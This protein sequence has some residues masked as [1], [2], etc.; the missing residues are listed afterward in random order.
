MKA[1]ALLALLAALPGHA[2]ETVTPAQARSNVVAALPPDIA[3]GAGQGDLRAYLER[4]GPEQKAAALRS[5]T[6]KEGELGDD[7]ATLNVIGQAYAGLGKV[8]EARQAAQ[9][10]L[11]QNPNDPEAKRLMGWVISQEKLQGREGGGAPGGDRPGGGFAPAAGGRQGAL[12]ALEQRIERAFRRGQRSAEFQDTMQD[13]RG[14]SVGELKAAGIAFQRAAPDQKDAVMITRQGEGFTISIRDDAL[15]SGGDTEA[16]AAAQ[17]ANGVR[18]AQTL[19]DHEYIGWALIRARG[20]ISGGRTHRELAPNDSEARPT[21][22]SDQ[23]LMVARKIV[24]RENYNFDSSK[25]NYGGGITPMALGQLNARSKNSQISLEDLFSYFLMSTG[26][27]NS[28]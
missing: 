18:Q 2:S 17:V 27:A 16:R 11:R 10:A 9:A 5:L 23:N 19:R 24:D 20:W 14:M 15:N 22:P 21:T 3:R 1:A 12:N 13:A 7:P 8:T 26:R 28:D 6:A 4:L 25:E